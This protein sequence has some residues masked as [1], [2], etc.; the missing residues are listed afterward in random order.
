MSGCIL[1][2]CP[3]CDNEVCEG[4]WSGRGY[5]LYDLFIHA[6]ECFRKYTK[7][8]SQSQFIRELQQEIRELRKENERIIKENGNLNDELRRKIMSQKIREE[9]D[10]I[11][12]Q[13]E[14]HL[15]LK[16]DRQDNKNKRIK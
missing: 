11:I 14:A 1:G 10:K 4:D 15:R 7:E 2:W 6:G 12:K 5:E 9:K 13:N 8:K 3:I 16:K